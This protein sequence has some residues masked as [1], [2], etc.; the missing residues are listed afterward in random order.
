M[1]FFK[2]DEYLGLLEQLVNIDSNSF[3]SK[4][5]DKVADIMA[6]KYKEL[7]LYV[8]KHRFDEKAG[9]CLEVRNNIENKEIDVLMVGHIDT[10]LPTGTVEKRPFKK[11]DN[12]A[13]GPGIIDMKSGIVSMYYIVKEIVKNNIPINFC[14][15]I[16]SDEEISSRYSNVW[17]SN[18][19]KISKCAFIFEPAR[20]SGALVSDRKGLARF[21][22]KFH[23]KY[24][25]A[26]VNPQDGASAIHEMGYWISKIVPLNNYSVGTTVNV[27]IV[28]GG[29]GA[30]TVAENAKC[31]IDVRFEVIEEFNKI[32]EFLYELQKNNFIQGVTIS[33]KR[34]GFRPPMNS[35]SKA[36]ELMHIM[37]EEGKKVNV[38]VKWVKTG[39]GSDGNFI[40]FEGCPVL[41]AVGPVGD[42]AHGDNE[43]IW[44]DS[45]EPRTKMVY[46]TI[47][48]IYNLNILNK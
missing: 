15:A 2:L 46:T 17:I 13:Y 29:V 10:V 25:H 34:L 21:E 4:G 37:T 35:N 24:S 47:V 28:S 45:I 41:D 16:N 40:S 27:G 36:K 39:G 42:G 9:Y 30:N 1:K 7:G 12:I 6:Q 5:I 14:L 19:G 18:L 26:G 48:N 31:E 23:G 20:K 8:T 32:E 11:Q 3:D 38:D 22:V 43:M 33:I 44:I